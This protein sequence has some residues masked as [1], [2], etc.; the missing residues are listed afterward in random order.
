MAE[1]RAR[2]K[3]LV[4][5]KIRLAE[6]LWEEQYGPGTAEGRFPRYIY[7]VLCGQQFAATGNPEPCSQVLGIAVLGWTEADMLAIQAAVVRAGGGDEDQIPAPWEWL[8][9]G[10]RGHYHRDPDGTYRLITTKGPPP[11]GRRRS[12]VP[13]MLKVENWPIGRRPMPPQ[14]QEEM[15]EL[16]NELG[17]DGTRRVVGHH[18]VLP[19]RIRCPRCRQ[20]NLV[21]PPDEPAHLP[22]ERLPAS[23]DGDTT[24]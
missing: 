18:P 3:Q 16:G 4:S 10:Y 20:V 8:L 23:A 2:L 6:Q 7:R 12:A 14:L 5:Q 9:T 19:A 1:A 13:R 11:P 17:P 15:A 24:S 21:E 22:P